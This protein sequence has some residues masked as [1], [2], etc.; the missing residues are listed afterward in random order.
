MVPHQ[1]TAN[2]DPF[3]AP[4]ILPSA[5]TAAGILKGKRID[6]GHDPPLLHPLMAAAEFGVVVIDQ[7]A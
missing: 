7:F 4:V 3:S 2:R 6:P 1:A 5:A